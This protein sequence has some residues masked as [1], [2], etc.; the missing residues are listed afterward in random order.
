MIGDGNAVRQATGTRSV[1][2]LGFVQVRFAAGC[3][4][5]H[6]T[7]VNKRDDI[8]E[9]AADLKLAEAPSCS[10]IDLSGFRPNRLKP[11]A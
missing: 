7:T 10:R 11:F 1:C 5:C 2:R 6:Y 8:T 4:A 3:E 9:L